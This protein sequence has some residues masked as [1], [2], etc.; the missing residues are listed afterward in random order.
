MKKEKKSTEEVVG[1]AEEALRAIEKL[2][3]CPEFTGYFMALLARRRDRHDGAALREA[4]MEI[5]EREV[6][7][8]IGREYDDLLNALDVEAAMA[9]KAIESSRF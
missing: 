9:R 1:E 3:A 8:R 5:Q 2:K 6:R 4:N 7:R